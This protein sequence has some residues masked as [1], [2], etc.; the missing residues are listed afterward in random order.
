MASSSLPILNVTPRG[1]SPSFHLCDRP[2]APDP[3]THDQHGSARPL[4]HRR[5]GRV[6][7][8]AGRGPLGGGG[9]WVGIN[10]DDHGI[11]TISQPC[12]GSHLVSRIS[13]A[14]PLRP[15]P[16]YP[17]PLCPIPTSPI[18]SHHAN[19]PRSNL[20]PKAPPS[21]CPHIA[22][23]TIIHSDP[24]SSL[25][26]RPA[27][28]L[29]APS[30]PIPTRHERKAHHTVLVPCTRSDQL[31]RHPEDYALDPTRR[32]ITRLDVVAVHVQ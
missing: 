14:P 15:L 7:N 26:P 22:F 17:L 24:P 16:L 12:R 32:L 5:R 4:A 6:R 13:L 10:F 29:S 19:V 3:P 23:P 8:T 25:P 20:A 18:P 11:I 1:E 27:W 31:V 21:L 30:T 28:T 2:S 9:A